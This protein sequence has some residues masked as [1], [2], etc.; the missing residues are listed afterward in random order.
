MKHGP[1]CCPRCQGFLSRAH[2]EFSCLVCGHIIYEGE[3]MAQRKPR[4]DSERGRLI[5]P[6]LPV[7][8]GA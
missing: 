6:Q 8:K 1:S 7:F 4:R 3:V 5:G 2:G